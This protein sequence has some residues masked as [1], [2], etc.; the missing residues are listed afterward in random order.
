MRALAATSPIKTT[1]C[2]IAFLLASLVT[3]AAVAADRYYRYVNEDGVTVMDS[4]IPPEYVDKGYEIV[5][6]SGRVLEVVPPAP[7]PEERAARERERE[8][9]EW[10][11]YL[12]RRYSSVKDIRAAK[13]RKLADFEASMSILRGNVSGLESQIEDLQ[14]RAANMERAGR[15]VPEVLLTNLANLQ[16]DL[17]L[18]KQKIELRLKDKKELAEQFDRE[19]ERFAEIKSGNSE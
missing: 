14:A 18:A 3:G 9:A 4:K 16:D 5:T 17:A 11:R 15:E 12:L 1:L 8:L 6:T 2:I 10:D 7:S 13:E 19:A